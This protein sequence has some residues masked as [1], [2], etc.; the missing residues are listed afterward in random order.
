MSRIGNLPVSLP[1]P[2]LTLHGGLS[3]SRRGTASEGGSTG[4]SF[5]VHLLGAPTG[6]RETE[7]TPARTLVPRCPLP[8]PVSGLASSPAVTLGPGESKDFKVDV[9]AW[10]A[11]RQAGRYE[12]SATYEN[13]RSD[14]V[15]FE[16]LPLKVVNMRARMLVSR[17]TD[18]ERRG[19]VYPFMFY[20]VRGG[21]RFDEVVYRVRRGRGG[22]EHYEYHRL[23]ETAPGK[24]PQMVTSREKPGVVGVLVPDKRN[25]SLS[26][27]FTVDLSVRPLRVSGKEIGHD[28]GQAPRVSIDASGKVTAR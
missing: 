15:E 10:Y 13:E 20:V 2:R 6:V 9:G 5:E 16:V 12:I 18:F 8:V 14:P 19:A 23:S 28:P 21:G 11:I 17:V 25:D 24:M 4:L 3:L 22:D 26:R 27:L 1:E 7:E